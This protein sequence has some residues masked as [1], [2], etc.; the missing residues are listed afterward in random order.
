PA[1]GALSPAS[2]RAARLRPTPTAIRSKAPPRAPDKNVDDS[3]PPAKVAKP[4]KTAIDVLGERLEPFQKVSFL[5]RISVT[6]VKSRSDGI[7]AQTNHVDR[8]T[9]FGPCPC[10][11]FGKHLHRTAPAIGGINPPD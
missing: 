2:A 11:I 8:V 9:A 4:E 5:R 7:A 6:L 3:S 10:L 1:S